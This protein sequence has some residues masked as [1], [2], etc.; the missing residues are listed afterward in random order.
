MPENEANIWVACVIK[1][2]MKMENKK[3]VIF[4]SNDDG[5]D[6]KG[7]NELIQFLRPLGNLVVVAPDSPRSG[8]SQALTAATPITLRKISEEPGLKIYK[9]SG[10]PA[11]CVKLGGHL[12]LPEKPDIVIGGINHGD[13]SSVNVHYSGTMGVVKEG[14]LRGIPSV[15]FSICDH[16]SDADFSPLKDSIQQITKQVLE[17]GLPSR[18]CLNVNYPLTTSFKGTRICRQAEGAW[19]KEWECLKRSSGTP[20]YFLTGEFADVTPLQEDSDH[21]ALENGY[22]AITPTTV[23]LTAYEVLEDLK[24]WEL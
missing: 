19:T 1:Y 16:S 17:K 22:I 9:C 23:D 4:I 13:N 3:P 6:A 20:Y 2:E 14:C 5:Y 15:A 18:V 10:T 7:I 8:M 11:D 24:K 21:W 12:M